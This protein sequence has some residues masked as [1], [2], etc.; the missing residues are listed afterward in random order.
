MLLVCIWKCSMPP[1]FHT[2][3]QSEQSDSCMNNSIIPSFVNHINHIYMGLSFSLKDEKN[4]VLT[5][6][7]WLQMVSW[8]NGSPP[9]PV[10]LLI[11]HSSQCLKCRGS[12]GPLSK[13]R[14]VLPHCTHASVCELECPLWGFSLHPA[15][16]S[17]CLCFSMQ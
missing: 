5:T 4:Q 2:L 1:N 7:I 9:L 13:A 17:A 12:R 8:D 10:F 15:G 16:S 6:N 14:E 3:Q 11:L